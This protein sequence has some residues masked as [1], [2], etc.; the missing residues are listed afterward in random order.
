MSKSDSVNDDPSRDAYVEITD[1]QGVVPLTH[2][3]NNDIKSSY[4][5]TKALTLISG[6]TFLVI[7]ALLITRTIQ[8]EGQASSFRTGNV[9]LTLVQS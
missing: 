1:N 3:H 4:R 7:S 9:K 8:N 5:S 6:F 2:Y